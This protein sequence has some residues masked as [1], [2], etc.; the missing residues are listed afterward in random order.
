MTGL[1]K[2]ILTT[3]GYPS[4][5]H[6]EKFFSAGY[7]KAALVELIGHI[8]KNMFKNYINHISDTEIDFPEAKKL[9]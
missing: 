5:Y 6:I 9:N 8:S 2:E 7:D 4:D 1:A 3:K